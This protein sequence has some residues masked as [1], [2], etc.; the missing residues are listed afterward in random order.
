MLILFDL[1]GTL[2]DTSHSTLENANIILRKYNLKEVDMNIVVSNMGKNIEECSK[3]YMPEL[4]K[5]KRIS[6]QKEIIEN[7]TKD[8]IN[9]KK[10]I[11]YNGVE[12]TIKELKKK[13]ILG[14]VTNSTKEY[15]EAFIK[16]SNLNGYFDIVIGAADFN[17]D[18]GIV[19]KEIKEQ[20]NL[21]TYYVGDTIMDEE[22][23]K[24][25]GVHFVYA[26]YGFGDSVDSDYQIDNIEQLVDL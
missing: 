11:I 3:S 26:S 8:I 19:L 1:D 22:A 17:L 9:N 16:Q 5:D 15:A 4:E 23:A 21:N 20:Y 25:A 2:W 6:I 14:I 18:K 24:Y 10:A 12:L 13:Y 7:N